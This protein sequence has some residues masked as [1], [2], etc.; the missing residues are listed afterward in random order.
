M[1]PDI[2]ACYFEIE[3]ELKMEGKPPCRITQELYRL[4]PVRVT[5]LITE[6]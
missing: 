4:P 5:A 3:G 6:L 1:L 2:G